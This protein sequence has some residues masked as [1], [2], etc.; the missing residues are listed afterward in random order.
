M[1]KLK[2]YILILDWVDLG[3]AINSVGHAGLMGYLEWEHE[4]IMKEWLANSFRKVTC[5]VNQKEFEHAKEFDDYQIITE[6]A[7]DGKE[8]GLVFKPRYEW[9]KFFKYL[10]LYKQ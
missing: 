8:V 2:M 9:P 6:L 1:K 5:K 4:P 10:K 3:H 7:F